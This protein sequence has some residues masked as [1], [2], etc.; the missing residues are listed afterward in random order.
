GD[1]AAVSSSAVGPVYL[2]LVRLRCGVKDIDRSNPAASRPVKNVLI[3]VF[4]PRG[5]GGVAESRRPMPGVRRRQ[6]RR[7]PGETARRPAAQNTPRVS[8]ASRATR[9]APP[10]TLA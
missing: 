8:S 10:T 9:V 7:T 1:A 3:T 6:R 4:P 5:P 2:V